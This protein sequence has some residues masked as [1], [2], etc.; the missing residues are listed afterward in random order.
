VATAFRAGADIAD[1][2]FVQFH[3]TALSLPGAPRFLLSEALR[4]EGAY[5]RNSKGERF[6][7][8]YHPLGDLAPRD[9]VARAIVMEMRATGGAVYLDLTH[10][11]ADHI[12][13]RFPR[14]YET[15]LLFGIDL[16]RQQAPVH[17]AAHYAMGGRP[18]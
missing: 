7:S 17:P 11:G 5:L 10:L 15:C 12:R 4:G 1:L 3:P 13:V 16:G 6:M 14:I 2:E 18:H 8:R 9:V